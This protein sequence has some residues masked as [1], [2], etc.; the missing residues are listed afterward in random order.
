[1]GAG[2]MQASVGMQAE[3]WVARAC[4]FGASSTKWM[5]FTKKGFL[6]EGNT[7][8]ARSRVS[9]KPFVEWNKGW[10]VHGGRDACTKLERK[11]AFWKGGTV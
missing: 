11:F 3:G 7:V 10:S 4:C 8:P 2:A 6:H 5:G 1:M 9:I